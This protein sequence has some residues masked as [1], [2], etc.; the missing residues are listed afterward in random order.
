MKS[1]K[2]YLTL[3]KQTIQM[4]DWRGAKKGIAR[5][6]KVLATF[7]AIHTGLYALADSVYQS[8]KSRLDSQ[9][10]IILSGLDKKETRALSLNR[11]VD[12]QKYKLSDRPSTINP[13]HNLG[14]VFG[15][16]STYGTPADFEKKYLRKLIESYKNQFSQTYLVGID[17]SGTETES[18]IS[19][20]G[21][22]FSLSNLSKANLSNSDFSYSNFSGARLIET[23]LFRT[24]L[25]GSNFEQAV[26]VDAKFF[27]KGKHDEEIYDDSLEAELF[28]DACYISPG[29][30]PSDIEDELLRTNHHVLSQ[31]S[32][33]CGEVNIHL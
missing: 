14:I 27:E 22:N 4:I 26:I 7:A 6:W 18:D 16:E 2:A 31:L 8:S 20:M 9:F 23:N 13:L 15:L 11:I 5:A 28:K 29:S 33:P 12:I 17:L 1:A 3:S 10:Q 32:G 19:L 25:H 30:L 21:S 24:S